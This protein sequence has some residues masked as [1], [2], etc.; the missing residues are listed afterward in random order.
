MQVFLCHASEQHGVAEELAV[1]MR[2]MGHTVFLD[3]DDLPPGGAY[4]EQIRRAIESSELFVFLLSPESV[5]EGRYTRTELTIARDKW[6]R[7]EGH[8]LPLMIAETDRESWP[9]YLRNVTVLE[10][11]GNAVAETL[12]AV[13]RL[14]RAHSSRRSIS[15]AALTAAALGTLIAA[16]YFLGRDQQTRKPLVKILPKAQFEIYGNHA[17]PTWGETLSMRLVNVRPQAISSYRCRIETADSALNIADVRHDPACEDIRITM[18]NGPFLAPNSE[19]RDRLGDSRRERAVIEVSNDDGDVVWTGEIVVPT[20]NVMSW[21]HFSLS[22]LPTPE[23]KDRIP[24]GRKRFFV[25]RDGTSYQTRVVHSDKPLDVDFSCSVASRPQE[26][27]NHFVE[28]T[29]AAEGCGFEVRPIV[30]RWRSHRTLR[31]ETELLIEHGPT[32]FTT[33][34]DL[35]FT[36]ERA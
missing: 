27:A 5:Q 11:S 7:P 20:S 34:L 31:F 24:A 33:K 28:L 19:F 29:P 12:D 10:P 13:H 21:A 1:E 2:A 35:I 22:G 25:V 32:G 36:I 17:Y 8:V 30:R 23:K 14:A 15:Y 18:K 16:V 26:L 4:H 9:P 3:R 6:P